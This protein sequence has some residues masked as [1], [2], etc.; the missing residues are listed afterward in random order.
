MVVAPAGTVMLG[1]SEAFS[2]EGPRRRVTIG[3]PLAV[4]VH[5]VTFAEWDACVAMGGCGGYQP[6]DLGWGRGRQPV[7]NVSWEDTQAYLEWLS[8]ETGQEY[9]L[10]RVAEWEYVIREGVSATRYPL[11]R[12][13]ARC[14][15]AAEVPP[16]WRPDYSSCPGRVQ[17]APVGSL[18]PNGFGLHDLLG[19]A[20]EWTED[21][22]H[23]VDRSVPTRSVPT[24]E[25]C[26]ERQLR[27]GSPYVAGGLLRGLYL[28]GLSI[29]SRDWGVG[30]RVAR[31]LTD[32]DGLD[33][34][35]V[36]EG[37]VQLL[38]DAIRNDS[39]S[40]VEALSDAGA[41]PNADVYGSGYTP[42]FAALGTAG[43]AIVTALLE[44]GADPNA[45]H[46]AYYYPSETPLFHALTRGP[47]DLEQIIEALLN[48]G[49]EV[50][51]RIGD[52]RTPLHAA[53]EYRRS[54]RVVATLLDAGADADLTPLQLA[55]LKNDSLAVASLLAQGVDP[56]EPDHIGWTPLHFAVFNDPPVMI[57]HLIDAGADPNALDAHG[58]TPLIRHLDEA[59]S[60]AD[61]QGLV[62]Q[63]LLDAGADPNQA[64]GSSRAPLHRAAR[65]GIRP[66]VVFALLDA[67]SDPNALDEFGDPPLM[68][69][70]RAPGRFADPEG[71]VAV[72]EAL[73]SAGADP[74]LGAGF[75][76]GGPLHE[77]IRSPVHPKIISLLLDAGADPHA[78]DDWGRLPI[79][80]AEDTY[81][82]ETD[83]YER[84]RE[85]G[86][87][88]PFQRLW[89]FLSG[90]L[91]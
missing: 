61:R 65:Y 56:D 78:R 88:S 72:V 43:P 10:L 32:G 86:R 89:R 25:D 85:L 73:L 46:S 64:D 53:V 87:G 1:S 7:I 34:S 16:E 45:R 51:A 54:E 33:I 30:F 36:E 79:D 9:R 26:A 3:S 67:G 91:G 37:Y 14:E 21:C 84:L 60:D 75:Q 39:L 6:S 17:L 66:A 4:G 90:I 62:V 41:D 50:N 81:L 23:D 20:W 24:P 44:A 83:V 82:R 31:P 76:R 47:E 71:S 15:V 22:S 40:V 52:G 58:N 59:A 18:G 70:L 12:D 38:L 74:N 8:D 28:A 29:G 69:H 5:E 2:D 77:A 48:G 63:L 68:R 42:L 35:L 27:G 11:E 19:N 57:V 49:A 55:A 13:A 80:L